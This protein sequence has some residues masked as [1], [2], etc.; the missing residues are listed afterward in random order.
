MSNKIV[1]EKSSS[2]ILDKLTNKYED[3]CVIGYGQ[4]G[5]GKTSTLIYLDKTKEDG[6]LVEICQLEEFRNTYAKISLKMVNL[7]LWH[8]TTKKNSM[9]NIVTTDYKYNT[10]S[11]EGISNPSFV[12]INGKWIYEGDILKKPDEQRGRG[13]LS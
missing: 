7:Y 11:I 2:I 4:S 3:I 6:V 8:G 13:K 5:S 1:A 9:D 12:Q 10:I